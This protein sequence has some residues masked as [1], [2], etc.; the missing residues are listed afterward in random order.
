MIGDSMLCPD[1][2]V[3]IVR[4][5]PAQIC[6]RR[7]DS[8]SIRD[9]RQAIV[10][11]RGRIQEW[12]DLG[13]DLNNWLEEHTR[14]ALIDPILAALGWNI[15]EP[16]EC[17][18]QWKYPDGEGRVDYALH[19]PAEMEH[20]ATREI[21]PYIIIE[22]KALRTALD[23]EPLQQLEKYANA[24]PRMR[25]G[26]AVLTDG[27]YWRIYDPA[28]RSAFANRTP[29]SVSVLGTSLDESS[30]TLYEHLARPKP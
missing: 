14:Y 29:T 12:D 13:P 2:G 27:N 5:Q 28:G 16:K 23:G 21:A 17:H 30:R 18:P 15:H 9:V 26:Y 10:E 25:G 1:T 3:L 6:L 7:W 20:I 4:A 22:A 24:R 8:M 11:V 19:T